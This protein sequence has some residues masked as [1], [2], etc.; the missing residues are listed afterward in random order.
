MALLDAFGI[1]VI[2]NAIDEDICAEMKRAAVAAVEAAK[3]PMGAI[4][5]SEFRK[6]QVGQSL[7]CRVEQNSKT[8]SCSAARVGLRQGNE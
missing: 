5:E 3:F 2:F 7:N 1:A 4:M 6:D 8:Q